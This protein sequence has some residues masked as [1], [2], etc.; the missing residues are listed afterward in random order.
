MTYIE[1]KIY[2]QI[3]KRKQKINRSW[4]VIPESY[5]EDGCD[6]YGVKY[7]VE[8]YNGWSGRD[9][10][11]DSNLNKDI[12]SLCDDIFNNG[13]R[14]KKSLY[15]I[16]DIRIKIRNLNIE[17]ILILTDF[18]Y[19]ERIKEQK[20][21]NSIKD[22]INKFILKKNKD[23]FS[24]YYDLCKRN[25][26]AICTSKENLKNLLDNINIYSK[27]I[28]N[29]Q[30]TKKEYQFLFNKELEAVRIIEKNWNICRYNPIYF[31]FK[32]IIIKNNNELLN[33]L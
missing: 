28:I 15:F 24:G 10:E 11:I 27:V 4:T 3:I 23:Y 6:E 7:W 12:I 8:C 9:W 22:K 19:S 32:K 14:V 31:I 25:W 21:I 2:N 13:I 16:N 1:S 5:E 30:L 17:D 33:E 20:I 18:Q 26:N 29:S